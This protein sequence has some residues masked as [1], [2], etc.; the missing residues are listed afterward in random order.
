[1]VNVKKRE[2]NGGGGELGERSERDQQKKKRKSM[3]AQEMRSAGD[4]SRKVSNQ[5]ARFT[6]AENDQPTGRKTN[7]WG[8]GGK[9]EPIEGKHLLLT[10]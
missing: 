10:D 9:N 4:P 2:G 6:H 1:V 7:G 3:T 5:A 8:P